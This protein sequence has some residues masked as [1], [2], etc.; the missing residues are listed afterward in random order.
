[1][2]STNIVVGILVAAPIGRVGCKVA[3]R[4]F[5]R[6]SIPLGLIV[7]YLAAQ[8]QVQRLFIAK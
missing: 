8:Y 1:M 5:E 3:T 7:V 2:L 4:H 6:K